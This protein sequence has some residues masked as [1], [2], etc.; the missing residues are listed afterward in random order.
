MLFIVSRLVAALFRGICRVQRRCLVTQLKYH[1]L[2]VLCISE[3]E[4]VSTQSLIS[5]LLYLV[6]IDN[7]VQISASSTAA[8]YSPQTLPQFPL[9]TVY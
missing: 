5:V 1:R 4:R 9:P 7:H 3:D 2:H 6:R 8:L